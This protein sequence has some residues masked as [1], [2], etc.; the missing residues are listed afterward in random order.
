MGRAN[1]IALLRRALDDARSGRGRL[2]LLSGPPR[3]GKSRLT[4]EF[5][6]L[7]GF[8]RVRVMVGRS[9]E[10]GGAPADWP[11]V[12]SIRSYLRSADPQVIARQTRSCLNESHGAGACARGQG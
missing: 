10:A 2:V 5:A 12:Q 4:A 7:V 9:W 6:E 11:W 1:E 8:D 3:I